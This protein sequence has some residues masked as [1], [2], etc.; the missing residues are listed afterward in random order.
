MYDFV[1]RTLFLTGANGAIGR[2]VTRLFFDCGANLFL[3]DR[4]TNGLD[5]FARSL[6]SPPARVGTMQLNVTEAS[7]VDEAVTRCSSL[8]GGIDFLVPLAGLYPESGLAA[9]S[10]SEWR[11][12]V[13]VNLNGVFLS[14]QSAARHLRE[15][16]AVVLV[17][18]IA[19]H[20]G[21]FMHAHYAAAKGGVLSLMRSAALELAPKTRV[22][23]VSPGIIASEMTRKLVADRGDQL[24]AQTPLARLGK[25]DE[26]ASVIAFLCSD[27]ASFITGE[28]VHVNGGLYIAG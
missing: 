17:S 3:T 1:G 19:A 12:V 28:T 22:N 16:S 15:S 9:M 14:L 7:Q 11:R 10:E 4:D 8:F 18:S 23:A 26:V 5:E 13:E 2:A 25:P 27:G 21:S 6:G 20:R 24:V